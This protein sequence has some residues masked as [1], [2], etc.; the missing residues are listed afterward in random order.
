MAIPRLEGA[1]IDPDC[2]PTVDSRASPPVDV[3][4]QGILAPMSRLFRDVE[5]GRLSPHRSVVCIGAFDGL[6]C[7]HQAL[8]RHTL[9]RARAIGADAVVISFEPLPREFFMGAGAPPPES[10]TVMMSSA[11]FSTSAYAS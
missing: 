4:L 10:S 6:H 3:A 2:A 5:G 1:L 9:A 11:S 7:G 8:V